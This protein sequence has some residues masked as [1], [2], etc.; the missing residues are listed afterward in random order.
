MIRRMRI[1]VFDSG[2]GGLITLRA[3]VAAL[4]QY[5]YVYFGDTAHMPYGNRSQ[6]SIYALTRAGVRFLFD[7]DCALVIIACNTASSEALR[8]I[9]QFFL[10]KYFVDRRVLG[11]IVPTV[12]AVVAT[13]AKYVE[14]LGTPAT[15]RS[16]AYP[17]EFQKIQRSIQ[18][19]QQAAPKI[20]TMIEEN[21]LSAIAPIVIKYAKSLHQKKVDTLVLAC[22]HYAL[23][24]KAIRAQV[25]KKIR[26]IA[27]DEVVP[28]KLSAYLRRHPEIEK[29]LS[30][31]ARRT[32]FVSKKTDTIDRLAAEWF[33]TLTCS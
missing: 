5:E 1:G 13:N 17:R 3:L 30:R 23:L 4:P 26:V 33:G 11:V 7:H 10:P 32:L 9:Q 16:H 2:V 31:N 22:T 21:A 14:V 19:F 18:V 6:K 29:I 8:K 25:G 15:V 24:K 27:Q 28:K 20:A 12:E